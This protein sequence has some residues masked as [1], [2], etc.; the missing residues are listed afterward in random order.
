VNGSATQRR[1]RCLTAI[2]AV[3]TTLLSSFRSVAGVDPGADIAVSRRN[4]IVTAVE[5]VSPAVVS[6]TVSQRKIVLEEFDPF[7]SPFFA[8]FL[9]P[10][11]ERV[12]QIAG[13]GSGVIFDERGYILTNDHVVRDATQITVKLPDGRWGPGEL[14]GADSRTDIALVQINPARVVK[15]ESRTKA[16]VPQGEVKG[17]PHARLGS[18]DDLMIGEW[19]I[20]I[21]NPFGFI[22][23]DPRPSV[24]VGV[25]SAVDR[26][27]TQVGGEQR[28]YRGMIQTDAAINEGNSGGPLVSA[29]GEVVGISTFIVSRT[30]GYEGLGFAI[31]INRAKKVVDEILRYGRVREIWWG[32]QLEEVSPTFARS[33]GLKTDRGGLVVYAILRDSAA[34]RA[35]LKAGD[36][37]TAVNGEEMMDTA[38]FDVATAD[39]R[40]DDRVV[41]DVTRDSENVRIEFTAEEAP[42]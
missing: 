26:T 35:G 4:A 19:V 29:L 18:S 39:I 9:T 42:R 16:Q 2:L 5:K 34:T 12:V 6:I 7:V 33:L 1:I 14:R 22:I 31:P 30:G 8:P 13:I 38:G 20:A 24:S 21:G 11:R 32:F 41:L 40:V 37:V 23:N 15:A 27:F 3:A 17:L 28:V 36:L 25:I 10:Y